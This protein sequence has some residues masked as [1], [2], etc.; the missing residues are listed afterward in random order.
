MIGFVFLCIAI[1][2]AGY[3]AMDVYMIRHRMPEL[4]DA[5]SDNGD[6]FN[7]IS[8]NIESYCIEPVSLDNAVMLSSVIS[9]A[10]SY[11]FSSVAFD[12]K[13]A[14]GSVAY[15]SALANVDA[16][17][18]VAFPS[19]KFKDSVSELVLSDILPVGIVS[20][21][22]DNVVPAKDS[23]LA[24]LDDSGKLYT[25]DNGN[26]YLNPNSD[27]AYG[28]IK[29]IIA[30][31]NSQGVRVFVLDETKLPSD[32]REKY[33]DGFDVI[34]AKLYDDIGSDIKLLEAVHISLSEKAA[35]DNSDEISEKMKNNLNENQV[36]YIKTSADKYLIKEK[37]EGSGIVNFI[38][39]D[40]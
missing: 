5:V 38:L 6:G 33:E 35:D 14:D 26:T 1:V 9:E 29:D 37:L 25:D 16:Y 36:Y 21:Y 13:R 32:I 3:A 34:S 10:Q 8:I 27:L 7:R 18:A 28:Y 11:S 2:F 20:C 12:I 23:E 22:Q 15:R 24:V 39:A 19:A 4:A 31:A 40:K 30:E 17:G